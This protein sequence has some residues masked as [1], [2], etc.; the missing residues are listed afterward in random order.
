MR[1]IVN[2]VLDY[3]SHIFSSILVVRPLLSSDSAPSNPTSP[4]PHTPSLS[5]TPLHLSLTLLLFLQPHPLTPTLAHLSSP[6]SN[7]TFSHLS[8]PKPLPLTTLLFLKPHPS[9]PPIPPSH[10]PSLP[11]TPPSHN[12]SL[13]HPIPSAYEPRLH[14][15]FPPLIRSPSNPTSSPLSST[16]PTPVLSSI[17]SFLINSLVCHI[18]YNNCQCFRCPGL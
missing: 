17:S 3:W 15:P 9:L 6:I 7:P 1:N 14:T 8:L 10:T 4:F 12:P 11:P 5:P 16:T 18:K 2:T 13:P